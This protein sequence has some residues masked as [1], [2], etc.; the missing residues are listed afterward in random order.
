MTLSETIHEYLHDWYCAMPI[1]ALNEIH[2]LTPNH[3]YMVPNDS[4]DDELNVLRDEWYELDLTEKLEIHDRLHD[5]YE[6]FT[7]QIKLKWEN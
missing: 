1:P 2:Q 3:L 7:N 5:K 6:S 4:F